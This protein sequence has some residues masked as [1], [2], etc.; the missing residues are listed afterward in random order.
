MSFFS[1]FSHLAD[2]VCDLGMWDVIIICLFL[3]SRIL[4]GLPPSPLTT[5][6]ITT[7][8][9]KKSHVYFF[10]LQHFFQNLTEQDL[11]LLTRIL[12]IGLVDADP[13]TLQHL[14]EYR[15]LRGSA[16]WHSIIDISLVFSQKPATP[17]RLRPQVT[18]RHFGSRQVNL[19]L[20]LTKRTMTLKRISSALSTC[21]PCSTET[22]T[23]LF[24]CF[25]VSWA[26]RLLY[27]LAKRQW[28]VFR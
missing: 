15:D 22:S 5:T 10:L 14:R 11:L 3:L 21:Y 16:T 8:I 17:Q 7:W 19:G 26:R 1:N 12:T 4:L 2:T 6:T 25:L 27:G 9:I 13:T 28:I 18:L 24:S 20:F 23:F